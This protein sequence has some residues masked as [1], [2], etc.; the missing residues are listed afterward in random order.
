MNLPLP[1][2]QWVDQGAL[3]EERE[4]EREREER[5]R[6][7]EERERERGERE[8][9]RERERR[10]RERERELME[11]GRRDYVLHLEVAEGSVV[12]SS[13]SI[14]KDLDA[15]C[16]ILDRLFKLVLKSTKACPKN[17]S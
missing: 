14:G 13:C 6:E 9:E 8:R 11:G 17:M 15:V 10:E 7:R 3:G 4:R 12:I 5:E 16:V 1:P 2:D